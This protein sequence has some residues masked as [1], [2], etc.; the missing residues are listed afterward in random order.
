MTGDVSWFAT[1]RGARQRDVWQVFRRDRSEGDAARHIVG[2]IA[3]SLQG[4]SHPGICCHHWLRGNPRGRRAGVG[5]QPA[6]IH[7]Q[8]TGP[9]QPAFGRIDS[10]H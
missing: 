1:V 10:V 5:T 8:D 3:N 6:L 9:A 4:G 2:S 7:P